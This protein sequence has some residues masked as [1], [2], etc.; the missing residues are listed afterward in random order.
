MFYVISQS[1]FEDIDLKFCAHIHEPLPSNILYGFLKILILR[2]NFEKE[3]EMKILE[4]LDNICYVIWRV[5]AKC[6]Y[7]PATVSM[8]V[9]PICKQ[10]SYAPTAAVSGR[11]SESA[12]S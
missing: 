9:C 1:F 10:Y 5:K 8:S 4:I 12:P 11:L 3:K 7:I 2:V 6:C